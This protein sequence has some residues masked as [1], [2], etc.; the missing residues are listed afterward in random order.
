MTACQMVVF[1]ISKQ[2]QYLENLFF[3]KIIIRS[4]CNL[5]IFQKHLIW[6]I[7]FHGFVLIRWIIVR[8]LFF[9]EILVVRL[10]SGSKVEGGEK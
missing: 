6:S 3:W 2:P 4:G 10:V 9:K 7:E 1:Q 8:L 5:V